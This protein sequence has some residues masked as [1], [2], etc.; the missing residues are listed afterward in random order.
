VTRI[1]DVLLKRLSAPSWYDVCAL[2]LVAMATLR[3]EGAGISATKMA[4]M[5]D[6]LGLG[7]VWAYG[8]RVR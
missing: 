2:R 5:L 1:G 6:L 8:S 7:D 4:Y 3:R